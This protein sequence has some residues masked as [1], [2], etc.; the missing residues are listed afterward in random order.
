[1]IEYNKA[2]DNTIKSI[3]STLRGVAYE[4]EYQGSTITKIKFDDSK[5]TAQQ[6]N[7]IKNAIATK[8]P[9]LI[10]KV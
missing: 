2:E 9:Q 8:Y 6:V 5:L 4:L 3:L 1:M 7:D 10:E